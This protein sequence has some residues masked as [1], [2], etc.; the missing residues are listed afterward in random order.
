MR[1][2]HELRYV[3]DICMS[4]YQASP[5]VFSLETIVKE[6]VVT[7]DTID[8]LVSAGTIWKVGGLPT[9]VSSSSSDIPVQNGEISRRIAVVYL[10]NG[11]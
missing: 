5:V 7:T 11:T 3:C 1:C 4:D 9:Q 10:Q 8:E 2:H 6:Q